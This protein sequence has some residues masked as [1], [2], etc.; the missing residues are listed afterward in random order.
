[1]TMADAVGALD[2]LEKLTRRLQEEL[3]QLRRDKA[4][5]TDENSQLREQLAEGIDGAQAAASAWSE[6]R[7]ALAGRVEELVRGLDEMIEDLDGSDTE[8]SGVD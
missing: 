4:E 1:M 8:R 2:R 3:V 5:L 7:D 6:E